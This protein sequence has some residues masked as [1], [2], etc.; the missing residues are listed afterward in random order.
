MLS[1]FPSAFSQLGVHG[2]E[3]EGEASETIWEHRNFGIENT[4]VRSS[5]RDCNTGHDGRKCT[6]LRNVMKA[7]WTDKSRISPVLK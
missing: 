1:G 5:S 2:R 3:C 4:Q 6:R 7:V